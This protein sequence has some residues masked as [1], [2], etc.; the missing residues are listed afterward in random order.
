MGTAAAFAG[1]QAR[2]LAC[3]RGDRLLFRGVDFAV[4]A[5]EALFLRGP[6]GSGKTSLLRLIAG[7]L[8][9]ESGEVLWCGRDAHRLG[10]AFR[11]E[12]AFLGHLDALKPQL[13]LRDNLAFWRA[14]LGGTVEIEAVLA[15]VG[16]AA[17]V[18]LPAQYLSAGQRR[19][20]GLA[21]LLLR[22]SRLWLLDEPTTAL[23][24]EGQAMVT[25]LI[26]RHLAAGGIAVISSHDEIALPGSVLALGRGPK[27]EARL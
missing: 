25:A 3:R 20:F 19:R 17:S 7:L 23:D 11:A 26:G 9:P 10:A 22:P 24:T 12:L 27:N 13:T 4:A 6:N 2:Q 14:L 1:L 16:L 8:A 18:D 21:R 5:G 15:E